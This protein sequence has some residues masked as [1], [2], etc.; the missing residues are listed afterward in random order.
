MLQ[1]DIQIIEDEES[2][3]ILKTISAGT[4]IGHK[5]KSCYTK[6]GIAKNQTHVITIEKIL[7]DSLI[8]V[9]Y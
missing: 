1:G 3:K 6:T 2:N 8:D 7:F 4:I 5:I 9:K